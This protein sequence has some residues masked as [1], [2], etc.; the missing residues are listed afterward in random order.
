MI[1]LDPIAPASTNRLRFPLL[2]NGVEWIGV[3]SAAATFESPDRT[4]LTG[5]VALVLE[6]VDPDDPTITGDHGVWY[7]DTPTSLV[8]DVAASLGYW[9]IKV[10]VIDGVIDIT[11]PDEISVLVRHQP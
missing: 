7:Y 4:T 2:K 10:R 9:T 1:S 5:P 6:T 11:Y 3:D 8:P